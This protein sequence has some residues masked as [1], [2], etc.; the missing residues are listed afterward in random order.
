M[1]HSEE[2]REA[3]EAWRRSQNDKPISPWAVW[4][5]AIAQAPAVPEGWRCFHCGE[6][7]TSESDA[8]AHFGFDQS[9]E[10]ACRIK[11]GAERGLLEAL[12]KAEESAADAW[13]KLHQESSDA[14][15]AMYSAL[16]RHSRQLIAV[17]ESGYQ[18]G[19]HD[20]MELS[21][22]KQPIA[23]RDAIIE[24]QIGVSD[25][26]DFERMTWTFRMPEGYRVWPGRFAIRPLPP[27]P[28]QSEGEKS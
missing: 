13:E 20:G 17:E 19:L 4:Q 9:C 25:E 22:A 15:K 2:Q 18:R 21:A 14:V 11:A 8:G 28:A 6:F 3:F 24:E 7:F 16:G 12:R 5:A 23:D 1:T 10:P 27:A 26:A